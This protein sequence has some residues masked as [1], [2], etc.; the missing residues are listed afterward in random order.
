[1]HFATMFLRR[2][3]AFFVGGWREFIAAIQPNWLD[4]RN[5]EGDK[6]GFAVSG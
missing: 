4:G 3:G 2:Q 1:M 6:A 5:G